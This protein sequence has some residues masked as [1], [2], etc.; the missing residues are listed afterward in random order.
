MGWFNKRDKYDREIDKRFQ[1]NS[2]T[3]SERQRLKE[4][5]KKGKSDN[6]R[7]Q[8]EDYDEEIWFFDEY[9]NP[10]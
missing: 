1:K 7:S 4:R 2:L 5:L 3:P 8:S 6:G 10:L 9:G